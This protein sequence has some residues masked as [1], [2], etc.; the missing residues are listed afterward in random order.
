MTGAWP[1]P[2]A[3]L[4]LA[5]VDRVDYD[6]DLTFLTTPDVDRRAQPP[7][8]K[9]AAGSVVTVIAPEVDRRSKP[10]TKSADRIVVAAEKVMTYIPYRIRPN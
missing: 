6:L 5:A 8:T 2:N 4:F 10:L 7:A 1:T 9:M 3:F